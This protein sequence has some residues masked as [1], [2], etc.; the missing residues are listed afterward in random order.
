MFSDAKNPSV[1][2][3]GA[4]QQLKLT[5]FVRNHASFADDA[6]Q[7]QHG[8][9]EYL[10]NLATHELDQRERN[11][12]T[13]RI[14]AARFPVLRELADFDFSA[15]P[16]LKKEVVTELAHGGYIAKAE[17]ILLIGNPGLGK[18]H[19]ATGLAL[20]ACRQS[21][22]VRFY[23]AAT[24]VNEL[25]SAQD[26]HTVERFID[27]ALRHQVIVLDEFGFIPLTQAGANLL[28]QFCSALNDRVSLILTSNLKF[29]DWTQILGSQTL[30]AALLDRLT[31]RAHILEFSGTDSYRLKQRAKRK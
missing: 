4:L 8:H 12:H 26:N 9:Q 28:F 10:L 13:Q 16:S 15:V 3:D 6:L 14:R 2:L 31:H 1:V 21:H 29:T 23:N 11:R 25:I 22:R 7:R 5:T 17:P 19:L 20:A 27:V 18:S 30:T 24:L